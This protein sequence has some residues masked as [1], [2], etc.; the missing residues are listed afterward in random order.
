MEIGERVI[1]K[2]LMLKDDFRG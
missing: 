2:S 1:L